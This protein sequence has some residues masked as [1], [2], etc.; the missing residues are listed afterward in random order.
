MGKLPP[1]GTPNIRQVNN[2]TYNWC[3]RA[4]G[5][6]SKK[7]CDYWVIHQPSECNGLRTTNIKARSKT[8]KPQ[9]VRKRNAELTVKAAIVA[10]KCARNNSDSDKLG[11]STSSDE[12]GGTVPE[13]GYDSE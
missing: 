1:K 12:S 8:G 10:L 4:T 5:A 3:S 7:G 13:P 9:P 2:K 11:A 6:P